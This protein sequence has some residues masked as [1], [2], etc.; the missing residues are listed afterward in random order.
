MNFFLDGVKMKRSILTIILLVATSGCAISGQ[1]IHPALYGRDDINY[2]PATDCESLE[3]N[4][5][6]S[7]A[8]E[9]MVRSGIEEA[10]MWHSLSIALDPIKAMAEGG[11]EDTQPERQNEVYLKSIREIFQE[12]KCPSIG[13]VAFNERL[14]REKQRIERVHSCGHD[15]MTGFF[16]CIKDKP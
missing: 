12:K 11:V 13:Y 4:Y 15:D 6:T 14:S 7:L 16:L 8:W 10:K 9:K 2:K 3:R 5:A 1:K